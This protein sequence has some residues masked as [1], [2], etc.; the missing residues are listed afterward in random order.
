MGLIDA[1]D[2]YWFIGTRTRDIPPISLCPG[3]QYSKVFTSLLLCSWCKG[4]VFKW[5]TT[6]DIG[7]LE[8]RHPLLEDIDVT[9]NPS[10]GSSLLEGISFDEQNKIG[11][12]EVKYV[13]IIFLLLCCFE[14]EV[15]SL[16]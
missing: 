4:I 11:H 3:V 13:L 16:G 15:A 5:L 1:P 14:H 7:V 10:K 12:L 9:I 6:V 2:M 8:G